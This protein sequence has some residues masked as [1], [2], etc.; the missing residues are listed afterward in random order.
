M[1]HAVGIAAVERDTGIGKDT[2]RVWERRYGF[3]QPVR[4]THGE[5]VYT[6]QQVALLRS[7]RRLMDQGFRPG[8]LF[9]L[10]TEQLHLLLTESV[11]KPVEPGIERKKSA[12]VSRQTACIEPLEASA[13]SAE[14][15]TG[16]AGMTDAAADWIIPL[17]KNQHVTVL[18]TSLMQRI[19][20][21]GP[22]GFV[23]DVLPALNTRVGNAW[24][25][26][27]IEV[28]EEHVYTELVQNA[29]R[30]TLQS[31][32][33]TAA[34]PRVLLT[35]VKNESHGLGLLMAE[36]CFAFEGATCTSLGVQ[37]PVADIV[38]AA[39][40]KAIDI[41][42][43]SF[44]AAYPWR[45]IREYLR[46]LRALLPTNIALWVGGSGVAGRTSVS[47]ITL[48]DDLRAIRPA[49]AAWRI[50]QEHT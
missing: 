35:T 7:V 25:R 12:M 33:L 2:L 48:M 15:A 36:I 42:A 10:S 28:Y 47:G 14:A 37:T 40:Q 21:S 19:A 27:D 41:V 5:R 39:R 20:K 31:L 32:S 45:H 44:S 49:I 29:L 43:L 17:L 26:G 4:N 9:S 16:D 34:S 13:E 8:K 38:L 50:L 23:L 18:R 11:A 3:P 1:A 24:L 22:L 30:S 6:P 46:E